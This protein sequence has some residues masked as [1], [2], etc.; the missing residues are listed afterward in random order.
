M[1]TLNFEGRH[2]AITASDICRVPE[3]VRSQN[4]VEFSVA[5]GK[6]RIVYAQSFNDGTLR[7][8]EEIQAVAGLAFKT[9]YKKDEGRAGA[10]P[11]VA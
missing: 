8:V 6:P 9:C 10:V 3:V 7:V 1:N 2:I 4:I 5:K 11:F